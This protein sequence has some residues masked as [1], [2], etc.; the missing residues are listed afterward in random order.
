MGVKLQ[1]FNIFLKFP[2]PGS[3]P[4]IFPWSCKG[5]CKGHSIDFLLNTTLSEKCPILYNTTS[6]PLDKMVKGKKQC[7]IKG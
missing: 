1:T 7:D 2:R 4:T 6:P 3:A 5:E